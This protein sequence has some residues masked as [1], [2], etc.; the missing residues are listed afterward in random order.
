MLLSLLPIDGVV[1][2][3]VGAN[4][5]G[6]F[7][8]IDFSVGDVGVGVVGDGWLLLLQADRPP[9]INRAASPATATR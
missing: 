1:P 6:P 8:L 9:I 7:G 4:E 5:F 3:T 2:I